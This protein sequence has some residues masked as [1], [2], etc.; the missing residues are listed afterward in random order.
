MFSLDQV[1]Y[2]SRYA[3]VAFVDWLTQGHQMLQPARAPP[4]SMLVLKLL[5]FFGC[6]LHTRKVK[7]NFLWFH[8]YKVMQLCWNL[9]PDERPGQFLQTSGDSLTIW[10][11]SRDADYLTIEL[12]TSEVPDL[13]T[14]FSC[15]IFWVA[16]GL[17]W[18]KTLVDYIIC[19]FLCF[20]LYSQ[21]EKLF[22]VSVFVTAF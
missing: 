8:S 9:K 7:S 16:I 4:Q 13:P 15:M 19:I 12:V 14:W 21:G 11:E 10:C 17:G 6:H 1:P 20:H 3:V 5:L 18:R 22:Q 2:D